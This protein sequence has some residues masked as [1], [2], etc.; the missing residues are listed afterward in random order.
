VNAT[1]PTPPASAAAPA[2]ETAEE[3]RADR[4]RRLDE[5]ASILAKTLLDMWRR[6]RRARREAT[7]GGGS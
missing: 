6:E 3:R 5:A 2:T 1:I 4:E 7:S